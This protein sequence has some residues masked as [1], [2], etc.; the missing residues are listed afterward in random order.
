M[1]AIRIHNL[2]GPEVLTWEDVPDPEPGPG[3]ALVRVEAAGVNFIDVYIRTGLYK[4]PELPFIPGQEAAGTVAAVGPGVADLA[5]VSVG[6]RVAYTGVHGAYA[7]LAAVPADRLVKL[8]DGVATRDGAAAMLQGMTAH[9]LTHSTYP[10]KPGDTCLVHAAAGGAGRLICQ[11]AK[12]R[13]ARVIGTASTPEKERIA[14][15]A[16]ADEVIN[17]TRQDFA[18]EAK[19]LTGGKGVQVVYDSVGKDTF[20]KSLDSLAPRG[21][22]VTFGQSSGLVPPVDVRTLN[23][24]GSLYLTRPSLHHYVHLREELV[25]RAGDVLGWIA[26]GK[27]RLHIGLELPLAEAAEAHRALEGRRTTGKVLLVT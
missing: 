18:A 4:G 8:P 15:E 25:E 17:Y 9:Y 14:R 13:G 23:A 10:L 7:E 21:T 26:E 11:I 16:G 19:R 12:L 5:E 3:Q 6:D 22:L 2:G 24:K 20:D 27:L 1:K